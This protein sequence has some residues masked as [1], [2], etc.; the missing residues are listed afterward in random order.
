MSVDSV[1]IMGATRSGKT[2]RLIEQ[3]QNWALPAGPA[4]ARPVLVFAATGDDRLKLAD[5]LT[6]AVSCP[7]DSTTPVGFFQDEVLLFFP[8]IAQQLQ[9]RVRFPVRLRPETEQALATQLWRSDLQ[10]GRLRQEGVSDYF[11]VRRALDLMQLAAFSGTPPE[12]IAPVLK[13]GFAGQE[14]GPELWDNLSDAL[15]RWRSWCLQQ[16]LLTYGLLTEL[17]WRNLLPHPTY[18]QRLRQRYRAVLADDVDEYPAIARLVFDCLLD[19]GIPGAFSFNPEGSIRA[20][21]GADAE[22]MLGLADRCRTV[23]LPPPVGSLGAQW[24]AAVQE[25]ISDPLFLPELPESIQTIQTL[26]RSQLLRQTAEMIVA[27]VQAGEVQPQDVAVIGAGV[28]AIARYT[29]REIL[30]SRG[31]AVELLNDQQPLVSSPL[32]RALLTLMALVYPG[33]GRLV[34]RDAVAEMLVVLSQTPVAAER[35]GLEPSQ[36]DPVRAGLLT[37]YCFIPDDQRPRLLPATTFARWD[38]LGYRA[39]QAYEALTAWIDDQQRQH[40][41]RLLPNSIT[42]LDRAI[43]KFLAGGSHLPYDQVAVLRELLE[44]AQ[45]YWDVEDQLRRAQ[46]SDRPTADAVG[47]FIRLLRDGTI[48]ADPFPVRAIGR[49]PSAVTIATLYQYRS[50][51]RFHRWQFWLDAGSALWLTG[52][53]ALFGAPL[54]QQGWSG[55]PWTAADTLAADRQRLQRQVLDLLNRAGSGSGAADARVYLCHSELATNGQEQAGPL[56]SLANAAVQ[57]VGLPIES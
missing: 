37:D 7:V 1:W 42:L 4:A 15:R 45:H 43:Q 18:Q 50:T 2:Q 30:T 12:E 24:G 33:L 23:T 32:V 6:A 35:A 39:T 56:L 44:T 31:I 38:R 13:D 20:G 21:L 14:G 8:L 29:L 25:W 57:A 53:G 3:L 54:F 9:L 36:I 16:G 19:H 46:R 28:D 11:M 41:D 55:R 22:A 10:S 51:R 47:A 5:R 49:A 17:Y 34:D 48:T 26:S 52:G 40:D 27:G